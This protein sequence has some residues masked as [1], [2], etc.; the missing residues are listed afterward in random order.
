MSNDIEKQL[1]CLTIDL[2]KQP[3]KENEYLYLCKNCKWNIFTILLTIGLFTCNSINIATI[4]NENTF[5]KVNVHYLSI[6]TIS[7]FI[8][9]INYLV[10]YFTN[11]NIVSHI[12]KLNC[13][14]LNSIVCWGDYI[15]LTYTE[16]DINTVIM[17]NKIIVLWYQIFIVFQYIIIS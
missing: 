5:D 6:F 13:I 3:K 7:Q 4:V 11:N 9:W 2:D 10:Y 16:N 1:A 17:I 12:L 14:G 8:T 15:L